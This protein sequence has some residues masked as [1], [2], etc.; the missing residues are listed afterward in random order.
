MYMG[1][2]INSALVAIQ[3][4]VQIA[5]GGAIFAFVLSG[6]A[7]K[8]DEG[9][10]AHLRYVRLVDPENSFINPTQLSE[11]CSYNLMDPSSVYLSYEDAEGHP[12]NGINAH[13]QVDKVL[14]H[15][16]GKCIPLS[17]ENFRVENYTVEDSHVEGDDPYRIMTL[18]VTPVDESSLQGENVSLHK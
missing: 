18:D 16:D 6:L 1:N 13:S 8:Y 10:I 2:K 4:G 9:D 14:L 15:I 7:G 3:N 11:F 5:V 12:M 17:S